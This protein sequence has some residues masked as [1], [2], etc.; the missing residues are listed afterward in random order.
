MR[1][2]HGA[3]EPVLLGV[4]IGICGW[5]DNVRV[6]GFGSFGSHNH[7]YGLALFAGAFF[8]EGFYQDVRAGVDATLQVGVSRQTSIARAGRGAFGQRADFQPA[9]A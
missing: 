5:V 2:G 9:P 3:D 8:V 4:R 1:G 7:Q 6:R